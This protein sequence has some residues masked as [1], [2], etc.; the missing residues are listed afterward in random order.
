[1][2]HIELA[3]SAVGHVRGQILRG[4]E[5]VEGKD[6]EFWPCYGYECEAGAEAARL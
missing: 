4:N 2:S 6:T 1:M 5:V 3:G